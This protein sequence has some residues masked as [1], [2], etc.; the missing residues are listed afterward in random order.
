M[1]E[2]SGFLYISVFGITMLYPAGCN[3]RVIRRDG[4][5]G[6]QLTFGDVSFT[7]PDLH[8]NGRVVACR[9]R[10]SSDVWKIPIDG[11]PID[12]TRNAVRVTHQTGHVQ[13]P[14]ASP[15]DAEVAYVSDSGGHGN[16]WIAR[17]DLLPL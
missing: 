14:S 7:D 10:S 6:R 16:L 3:L 15:D 1:V 4:G 13:T 2:M 11:S 5:G 12:N 17:V 8:A 9:F